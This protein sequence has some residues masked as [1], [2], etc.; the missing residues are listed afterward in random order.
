MEAAAGAAEAA[1][2]EAAAEAAAGGRGGVMAVA[3]KSPRVG[4]S[5]VVLEWVVVDCGDVP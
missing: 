5:G 1:A 3:G 4:K 2:A